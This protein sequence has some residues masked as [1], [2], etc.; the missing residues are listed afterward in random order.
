[1]IG[2]R[3]ISGAK[4]KKTDLEAWL[5][6]G[7]WRTYICCKRWGLWRPSSVSPPSPTRRWFTSSWFRWNWPQ[8]S[9]K[10]VWPPRSWSQGFSL[11]KSFPLPSVVGL[12]PLSVYF[13]FAGLVALGP[14]SLQ[15]CLGEAKEWIAPSCSEH[16]RLVR[17]WGR[18]SLS[19]DRES[20]LRESPF[21]VMKGNGSRKRWGP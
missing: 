5:W 8:M 13:S 3:G 11:K 7:K 19:T 17:G 9:E 15:P 6:P 18:P 10:Y 12:A 21:L 1:M 2:L 20:G 4:K 14:P 16:W